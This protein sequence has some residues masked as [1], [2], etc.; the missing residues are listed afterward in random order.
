M[1]KFEIGQIFRLSSYQ[2][3]CIVAYGES[4]N[5]YLIAIE[6]FSG[7]NGSLNRVGRN[8]AFNIIKSCGL[9]YLSERPF[10]FV[11]DD[12]LTRL[13]EVKEKRII[14]YGRGDV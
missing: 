7:H 13:E 4:E 5:S 6:K 3:C 11:D 2:K 10:W 12:I 9:K 1:R 8:K 14:Y